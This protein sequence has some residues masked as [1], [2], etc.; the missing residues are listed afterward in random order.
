MTENKDKCDRLNNLPEV[1]FPVECKKC[2]FFVHDI[3]G[4]RFDS[5]VLV[6]SSML[7]TPVF[8]W[9]VGNSRVFVFINCPVETG[10]KSRV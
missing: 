9:G 10:I 2:S 4:R 1:K 6:E 5:H 3:K 7:D 8:S